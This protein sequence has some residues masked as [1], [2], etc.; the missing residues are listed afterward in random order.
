MVQGGL[1]PFGMYPTQET[2]MRRMVFDAFIDSVQVKVTPKFRAILK[3]MLNFNAELRWT[4]DELIKVPYMKQYISKWVNSKEFQ[5]E[6]LLQCRNKR[7][8]KSETP[9]DF[10]LVKV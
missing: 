2:I 7:L 5:I 6:Y 3:G 8:V 1:K 9:E 4:V 10:H